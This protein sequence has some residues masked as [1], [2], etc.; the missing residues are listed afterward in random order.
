MKT[1]KFLIVKR[2]GTILLS[3]LLVSAFW[4]VSCNKDE[5]ETGDPYFTIDGSPTGLSATIATKTQAYTV[6]SNRPWEIVAQS[7][8]DWVRAFPDHGDGDGIFKI[9]VK[10]NETFEERVMDFAFVVDGEEQAVLFRVEQDANVPYIT[11]PATVSIPAAG[12]DVIVNVASNVTWTYTL[13]DE[14]W[15]T[16]Q[17]VTATQIK[18]TAAENTSIDPRSVTMTITSDD[19]PLVTQDVSLDQS[20]GTVVL[21]ENF[22]WL[23]GSITQI[24]YSTTDAVR[25]DSWTAEQ[26]AKGWTSTPNTFS[27]NQPLLYAC[28]GYVKLGKTSYGGDLISPK[29]SK[30]AGT[31]NV[32]VTFKAVPYM[33][34]TGTKDD[35]FVNISILGAGTPSLTQIVV[36]NWPTYPASDT[37]HAAY[38][39]AFWNSTSPSAVRTFTITGATS[40]TQIKFLGGDYNLVGIGAG[41]N[42]IFIDDIKVEILP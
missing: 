40:E 33:T 12:G 3:L 23:N 22:S 42:R 9:I 37:E 1:E 39:E 38:C 11:V 7:E 16:E 19:F 5:A 13:S 41:K 36:D 8:G 26:V 30:I 24:F 35:N 6:R 10:A 25:F 17:E 18:L 28:I 32:T 20:P 31:Q 4:L 2:T 21:E 27:S 15:L 34:K 14:T 29:L